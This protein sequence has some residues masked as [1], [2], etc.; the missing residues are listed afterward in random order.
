MG[1]GESTYVV[2][3][4]QEEDQTS[5][6]TTQKHDA[7]SKQQTVAH[8]EVNLR[9]QCTFIQFVVMIIIIIRRRK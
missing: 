9:T 1:D 6:C 4:S 3:A 7:R 8:G 5:E 2:E